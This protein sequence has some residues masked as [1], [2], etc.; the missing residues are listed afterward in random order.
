VDEEPVELVE[1]AAPVGSRPLV[2]VA[3]IRLAEVP[4]EVRADLVA[5]AVGGGDLLERAA[6]NLARGTLAFGPANQMSE[7]P[8]A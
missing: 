7:T 1:L 2:D 4:V 5:L 3:G 8:G 6:D